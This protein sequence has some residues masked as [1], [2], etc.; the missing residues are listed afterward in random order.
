MK[1]QSIQAISST[2]LRCGYVKDTERISFR[3]TVGNSKKEVP[4]TFTIAFTCLIYMRPSVL[5]ESLSPSGFVYSR[6]FRIS[7]GSIYSQKA[8][9][10]LIG[11]ILRMFRLMRNSAAN[12]SQ[13]TWQSMSLRRLVEDIVA[14][15]RLA[16][17]VY[18]ALSRL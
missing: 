5:L 6:I 2:V 17:L 15:I 13:P 8:M 14:G 10:V 11:L 9:A 3:S 16:G 1:Y 4:Y 7:Q 18:R 12:Q